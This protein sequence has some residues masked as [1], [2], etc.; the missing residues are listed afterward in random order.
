M[1]DVVGGPRETNAQPSKVT[2][3]VCAVPRALHMGFGPRCQVSGCIMG[4]SLASIASSLGSA[5]LLHLNYIT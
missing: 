5:D 1:E 2:T 3:I 4:Q